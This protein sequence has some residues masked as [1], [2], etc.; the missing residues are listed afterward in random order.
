MRSRSF[1]TDCLRRQISCKAQK[2]ACADDIQKSGCGEY[3]T[4]RMTDHYRDCVSIG[5]DGLSQDNCSS[6]PMTTGEYPS[7]ILVTN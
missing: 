5:L 6:V 7:L 3:V 1:L 2:E 4:K